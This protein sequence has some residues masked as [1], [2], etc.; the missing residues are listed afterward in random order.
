AILEA[1]REGKTFEIPAGPSKSLISDL[2]SIIK[3]DADSSDAIKQAQEY[4]SQRGVPIAIVSNG[5]QYIVFLA[6]R[7]DGVSVYEGKAVVF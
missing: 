6:S 7:Q 1:K 5:H 4:C 2:P 3:L